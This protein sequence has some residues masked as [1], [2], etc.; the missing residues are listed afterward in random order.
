MPRQLNSKNYV[1]LGMWEIESIT[2][3]QWNRE[4]PTLGS[5]VPVG[6]SAEPR[7]PLERWTI[8]LRFPCPHLTPVMDSLFLTFP[9]WKN[10]VI[11]AYFSHTFAEKIEKSM[12]LLI[13]CK[14]YLAL[15]ARLLVQDK[16]ITRHYS[17]VSSQINCSHCIASQAL[18]MQRQQKNW[19]Q[20]CLTF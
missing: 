7:F 17:N 3:V 12:N 8:W 20:G 5:A 19:I 13:V 16:K 18:A 1:L 4:I 14:L 2:G 11:K 10:Q 15:L 9:W 6:N